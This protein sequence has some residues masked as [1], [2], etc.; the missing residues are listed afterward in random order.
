MNTVIAPPSPKSSTD[1]KRLTLLQHQFTANV[2][3]LAGRDAKLADRLRAF[4]PID[5]LL[6]NAAGDAVMLGRRIGE[7][8]EVIPELV[9]PSV[10]DEAVKQL[11]TSGS[12]TQPALVAGVDRG[13][14]W[15]RL[16]AMPSAA[17]GVPGHRLP[18]FL[19]EKQIGRLWTALHLHDWRTMLADPRVRLFVG[20][21]AYDQ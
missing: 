20:E 17:A 10:A 15:Q 14:L 13:W 7:E 9:S 18:L 3:A 21:D 4:A 5:P 8:I 19:L 1:W 16:Y 2:A 12:L 11:C 6:V